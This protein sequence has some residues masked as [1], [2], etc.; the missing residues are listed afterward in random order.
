M[1]YTRRS[2]LK[3]EGGRRTT[4]TQRPPLWCPLCVT[5]PLPA[6]Y[7]RQGAELAPLAEDFC[8]IA[9]VYCLVLDILEIASFRK[10]SIGCQGSNY[11]S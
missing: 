7:E 5:F 6:S 4:G 1:H 2:G 11:V 8:Q 10:N 3:T 9:L